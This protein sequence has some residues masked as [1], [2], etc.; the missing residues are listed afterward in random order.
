MLY[1]AA[2]M[3]IS[4]VMAQAF[5]HTLLLLRAAALC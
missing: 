3:L 1:D 5:S 2:I 4:H